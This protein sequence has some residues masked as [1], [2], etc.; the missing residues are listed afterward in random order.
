MRA[1]G[2]GTHPL[3]HVR[4]VA[5]LWVYELLPLLLLQW[6]ARHTTWC[7][8]SGIHG[9]ARSNIQGIWNYSYGFGVLLF[10]DDDDDLILV[11]QYFGGETLIRHRIRTL[12]G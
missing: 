8:L 3:S 1:K 5:P 2:E 11:K 4:S 10:D 7:G 9:V 6:T 12:L